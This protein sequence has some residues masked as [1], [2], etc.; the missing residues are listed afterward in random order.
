M[1]LTRYFFTCAFA[2]LLVS[3]G[4]A[5]SAKKLLIR[6]WR[7]SFEEIIKQMPEDQQKQITQMTD[8][9]K[10]MMKAMMEKSY[11]HFKS[12]GTFEAFM[13][14]K[15][16]NMTWKLSGDNKTLITTE[17]TGKVTKLH[18]VELT[19]ERLVLKEKKE[20]ESPAIVFVSGD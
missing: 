7:V 1:K 5:Q 20:G 2:L 18:I 19:K 13:D 16:E 17:E 10:A 11:V 12:D 9:Q 14:G 8:E 15:K 6:N 4:Q 3:S